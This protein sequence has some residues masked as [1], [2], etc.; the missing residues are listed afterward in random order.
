[1][2]ACPFLQVNTSH[3][4]INIRK[5]LYIFLLS[6]FNTAGTLAVHKSV[7][8]VDFISLNILQIKLEKEMSV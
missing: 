1:M 3:I 2:P 7:V 5:D 4:L 6:G 8:N